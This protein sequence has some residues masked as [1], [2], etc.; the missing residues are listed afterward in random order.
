[1]SLSIN[2]TALTTNLGAYT[3]ENLG[4]LF[5]YALLGLE[6][7]FSNQGVTLWDGL[8]DEAPMPNVDVIDIVKPMKY[9]TFDPTSDAIVFDSRTMKVRPFKVDLHI[10]PQDFERTWLAH[11]RK[12]AATMKTWEEVPFAEFIMQKI[13]ERIGE[14]V[15]QATWQGVYNASGTTVNA[16]CD[17]F[18]TLATAGV[19]AGKIPTVA[20]GGVTT[21]N[22]I[23]KLD[24]YPEALG[25]A[26]S[27]K[28]GY[29]HVPR[30]VFEMYTKADPT[31]VGR[32]MSLS[33]VP[34]ANNQ[35]LDAV[36]L[37]GTDIKVVKNHYLSHSDTASQIICTT[38]N[39][40]FCGTDTMGS[41]NQIRFQEENRSIKMLLDGKWGVQYALAHATHAPLIASDAFEA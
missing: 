38:E 12:M 26:F 40:L 31:A 41:F 28:K 1:M 11:N 25:D 20:T 35:N 36:Y 33:E 22:V 32:T 17:G 39:N 24:E 30:K 19:A 21:S 4:V 10:Y 15:R 37:R 5:G 14:N 18:I 23:A 7:M 2:N 16:I 6:E 29:L 13:M 3:R 9:T 8:Q 34:G 27:T